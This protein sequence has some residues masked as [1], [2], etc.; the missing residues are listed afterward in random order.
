LIRRKFDLVDH[1]EYFKE[2]SKYKYQ[3]ILLQ[4]VD[5]SSESQ[6][7]TDRRLASWHLAIFSELD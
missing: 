7:Y 1:H 3:V 4:G 5:P 2:Y 6:G